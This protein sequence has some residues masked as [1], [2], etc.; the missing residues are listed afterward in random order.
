LENARDWSVS[1]SRFWGTPLPI[2]ISDDGE[3]IIVIG[4]I[5]ELEE[6]SGFKVCVIPVYRL[7]QF[8]CLTE[9]NSASHRLV[10]EKVMLKLEKHWN[11]VEFPSDN[12]DDR[13]LIYTVSTLTMSPFHPREGPSLEY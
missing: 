3:E 13:Q 9:L 5:Q 10:S 6:L 11:C 8:G 4:S 1:R 2:W 7:M 12:A